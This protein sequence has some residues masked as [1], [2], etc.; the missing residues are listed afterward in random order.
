MRKKS[1]LL[2]LMISTLI[3][4][5]CIS[6][7]VNFPS[8]KL[9]TH[10]DRQLGRIDKDTKNIFG[11]LFKPKVSGSSPAVVLL[12]HAGGVTGLVTEDWPDY[13]TNLGYV[14][15]T[16][17]S[18][19][20]RGVQP[21]TRSNAHAR[22]FN[23]VKDAYGAMDALAKLPFVNSNRV[24]VIGFSAGGNAINEV[25]GGGQPKASSG[26]QFKAAIAFYGR[27]GALGDYGERDV[28]LLQIIPELDEQ[29]A[30]TCINVGKTSAVEYL[31]LKGAHHSFDDPRTSGK[32][33]SSGNW[34]E[35]DSA[36]TIKAREVTKIF[37][38]K[39]LK[40]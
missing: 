3:L 12:H 16:V 25:I 6:N 19:G 2:V 31:V 38:A 13:L 20:S 30:S 35:Y 5:G 15:L 1:K 10:I 34:M 40:N 32:S 23:M 37:L 18:Y 27:C 17:D 11:F 4:T 9:S 24:A 8:A 14:V 26:R 21:G 33:D 36:A 29:R 7:G 22:Y 39:Y 28:P